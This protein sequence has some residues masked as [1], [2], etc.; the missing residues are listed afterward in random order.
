MNFRDSLMRKIFYA[1]ALAALT[2]AF[3]AVSAA[4]QTATPPPPAAP[5]SPTFP[6][7]IERTLANGLRVIVVE[8]HNI[9]LGSALLMVKTG[10]EADPANLAGLADMTASLLTKGTKTR[11]AP[12]IV[13]Q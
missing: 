12:Q 7:P 1:V 5:R 10:G 3:L 13:E 9:P 6:A 4:A 8:R 2:L 11:N